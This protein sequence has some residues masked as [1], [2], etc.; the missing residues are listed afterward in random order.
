M[1]GVIR[2]RGPNHQTKF[3]VTRESVKELQ[4]RDT[5]SSFI[6]FEAR[7]PNECWQSDVTHWR[8]RGGVEV[9]IVNI[10]DDHSRLAV[11]SRVLRTAT[12]PKGPGGVPRS[13]CTLGVP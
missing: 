12:A 13:G 8:L 9:E 6:R 1:N 5:R 4:T 3:S 2:S 7:L 10:I 11:G